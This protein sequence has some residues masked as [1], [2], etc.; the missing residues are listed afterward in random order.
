MFKKRIASIEKFLIKLSRWFD[1]LET[2]AVV[3][4][5]SSLLLLGGTQIILRK[6]FNIGIPDAD[7][8]TR[9]MVTWLAMVGAALAACEGRHIS[10]D[11]TGNLLQSGV[12][13]NAIKL[14]SYCVVIWVSCLFLQASY[15]Y[16]I[17]ESTS[18]FSIKVLGVPEWKFSIIFPIGFILI[19][20]HYALG[21][22][23]IICDF[24]LGR[25][26]QTKEE[27]R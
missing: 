11:L 1:R 3:I 20:F 9:N 19:I 17:Q 22:F 2:A 18:F 4:I 7:I 26:T 8:L 15:D 24:I 16:I 6:F 27:V 13:K 14:F 25:Q 10:I 23:F 12:L 5:M 21:A